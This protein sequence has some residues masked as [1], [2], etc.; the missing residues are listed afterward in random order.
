[1][2]SVRILVGILAPGLLVGC[3]AILG[4]LSDRVALAP[5]SGGPPLLFDA[6][7][8]EAS[9][10]GSSSG[11]RDASREADAGTA[12]TTYDGGGL[13]DGAGIM[14][15]TAARLSQ[16]I[17]LAAGTSSVYFTSKEG[18][19]YTVGPALSGAN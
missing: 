9:G 12:I 3:D 5:D 1:M 13:G 14:P 2:P 17:A 10:S 16:G 19:L 4:N 11:P 6:G 8:Q 7:S 15:T 18:S